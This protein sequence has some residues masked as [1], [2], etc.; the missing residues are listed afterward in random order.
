MQLWRL[1]T[2]L[3]LFYSIC[4]VSSTSAHLRSRAQLR[5]LAAGKL[6]SWNLHPWVDS[7]FGLGVSGQPQEWDTFSVIVWGATLGTRNEKNNDGLFC[8]LRYG[9]AGTTWDEKL[10]GT[11]RIS[12]T[13][14]PMA[15]SPTWNLGTLVTGSDE[16][17]LSVRV[18]ALDEPELPLPEQR[19]KKLQEKSR[20]LGEISVGIGTLRQASH[21]SADGKASFKLP[22]GGHVRLT[23]TQGGVPPTFALADYGVSPSTSYEMVAPIAAQQAVRVEDVNGVGPM[24]LGTAPLPSALQGIWWVTGQSSGSSLL[25]FGG[26]NNDGNGCSLG[27]ISG[28]KNSYKIRAEGDRVI[29]TS[30]PSGLD[31]IVETGDKVYRFEFDDPVNP[32]FGQIHMLLEGL[33]IGTNWSDHVMNSQ[34]H[35]LPDGD[36]EYPGSL[37]WLRNTT[38]WGAN[39]VRDTKLVQVMDGTGEKIEPAWSKFVAAEKDPD[40][41]DYAGWT[42]YKSVSPVASPWAVAVSEEVQQRVRVHGILIMVALLFLAGGCCAACAYGCIQLH[43]RT[44]WL[45][46]VWHKDKLKTLKQNYYWIQ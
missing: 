27:Y 15:R 5:R 22:G 36:V 3:S 23:A 43:R 37:V 20:L 44:N 45:L 34:M 21:R 14:E 33:A 25:S 4:P 1:T 46:K 32:T 18:F 42:F 19:G 11:G 7:D 39:L 9:P 10:R 35:L 26:P 17:E 16:T 40:N 41:R 38:V 31:K 8:N 13:S 2:I 30:E 12:N 6:H 24:I 28:E 29:S